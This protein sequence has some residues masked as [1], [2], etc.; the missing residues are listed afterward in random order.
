MPENKMFFNYYFFGFYIAKKVSD[1]F[2]PLCIVMNLLFSTFCC[3]GYIQ[4]PYG[5]EKG[6]KSS[7]TFPNQCANSDGTKIS[8]LDSIQTIND[9]SENLLS[10]LQ[11]QSRV[12]RNRKRN[13]TAARFNNSEKDDKIRFNILKYSKEGH[14]HAFQITTP[15]DN[16]QRF[17]KLRHCQNVDQLSEY[18]NEVPASPDFQNL[19]AI[20]KMQ[21]ERI[22]RRYE[23]L[24]NSDE[25]V[26]H[27]KAPILRINTS[28]SDLHTLI[29]STC[30]LLNKQL[31]RT[32]SDIKVMKIFNKKLEK[33]LRN[34]E[35]KLEGFLNKDVFKAVNYVGR[36]MHGI[37]NNSLKHERNKKYLN[38]R[39][40]HEEKM[41]Q[42]YMI[43]NL[44]DKSGGILTPEHSQTIQLYHLD[45]K[46]SLDL[47][48]TDHSNSCPNELD[49]GTKHKEHIS[50]QNIHTSKSYCVIDSKDDNS[51][52]NKHKLFYDIVFN[53]TALTSNYSLKYKRDSEIWNVQLFIKTLSAFTGNLK[54][55]PLINLEKLII[56][57]YCSEGSS[58]FPYI[59]V[60]HW[61]NKT[62]LIIDLTKLRP[63]RSSI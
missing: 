31:N 10:I 48:G 33:L 53:K 37:L 32:I 54:R 56:I 20:N 40:I 26:E 27:K 30:Y 44:N 25:S 3:L 46:K 5:L 8:Q 24:F 17:D 50:E 36:E 41:L 29:P 12:R 38:S 60:F 51:N 42:D 55:N 9:T 22:L 61:D 58:R 16:Y 45:L 34:I 23:T 7:R 52:M 19:P 62:A 35:S 49:E 15:V 43:D 2:H 14:K 21:T 47:T 59:I 6:K 39:R 4:I 13:V 28:E 11:I 1:N 63:I 57:I 18:A